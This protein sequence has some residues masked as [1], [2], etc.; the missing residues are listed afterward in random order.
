MK[1]DCLHGYFIFT[2]VQAGGLSDFLRLF[3]GFA[4]EKNGDHW[5][6]AQLAEA[7]E[8]SVEG[9]SWLGAKTKVT[10]SGKPW[11]IMRANELVFDF[12]EGRVRAIEE[13][14][15]PIAPYWAGSYYWAGGLILPGSIKADGSRVTDYSAWY[16][17][18]SG[19]FRFSAV[20]YD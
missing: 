4:F 16:L 8:Y 11:E 15:R 1:I 18:S 17:F 7:P 13:I 14:D 10:F 5:T 19:Q 3:P 20:K 9:G 2:E 6:F 12:V